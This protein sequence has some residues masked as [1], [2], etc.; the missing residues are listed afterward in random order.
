MTSLG[1]HAYVGTLNY[2]KLVPAVSTIA[3]SFVADTDIQKGR[4]VQLKSNGN[5]EEISGNDTIAPQ[6]PV[7]P[8]QQ[9]VGTGS[10]PQAHTSVLYT[11][12]LQVLIGYENTA[13][14]NFN[15]VY[16]DIDK[17]S[18]NP[19]TF[20]PPQLIYQ[21]PGTNTISFQR[22]I[23]DE[24]FKD[25]NTARGVAIYAEAGTGASVG[26]YIVPWLYTYANNNLAVG[27]QPAQLSSSVVDFDATFIKGSGFSLQVWVIT[28]DNLLQ[29]VHLD[30][31]SLIGTIDTTKKR[32]DNTLLNLVN[33][34]ITDYEG[35]EGLYVMCFYSNGGQPKGRSI[36]IDNFPSST[37]GAVA[38]NTTTGTLY[39]ITKR[40]KGNDIYLICNQSSPG[41]GFTKWTYDES[42]ATFSV[43]I[44]TNVS[45]GNPAS[46]EYL[47]A[48]NTNYLVWFSK[49]YMSN[50]PFGGFYNLDTASN[51]GFTLVNSAP[52]DFGAIGVIEQ[53]LD[54]VYAWTGQGDG[55]CVL[56]NL[57]DRTT[58]LN[59]DRVIGVAN[60]TKKSGERVEVNALGSISEV[61]GTT[62]AP[63]G[64]TYVDYKG[65][66]TQL[67]D[68]GEVKIGKAIGEND[69]L[70]SPNPIEV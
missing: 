67:P 7:A 53:D 37:L 30:F 28:G 36:Q 2:E 51:T 70:L 68:I 39:D 59:A 56:C 4:V 57:G 32:V 61:A 24:D 55:R 33:P 48:N 69:I 47:E 49:G 43:S 11:S 35:N 64:D 62:L 16:A 22:C 52:A 44:S 20:K 41:V 29:L 66:I 42:T 6:F 54:I 50:L 23:L 34:K 12:E 8:Y 3:R 19:F 5:V 15:L 31:G 17:T 25:P 13:G 1:K 10:T 45:S 9:F 21:A 58:N 26:T 60:E 38:L 46:I 14:R 63:L 65:N 18:A 40:S 27:T